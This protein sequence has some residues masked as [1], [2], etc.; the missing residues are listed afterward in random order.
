MALVFSP[1]TDYIFVMYIWED[2][3][4]NDFLTELDKWELIDNTSRLVYNYFNPSQPLLQTRP[5]DNP[6]GGAACVLPL[7]SAEIN[8]H[9][10]DENRFDANGNPVPTACYDWPHCRPFDNWGRGQ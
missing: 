9:N 4:D 10:I 8:L 3:L 6:Q 2:D 5:P 7:T 1:T